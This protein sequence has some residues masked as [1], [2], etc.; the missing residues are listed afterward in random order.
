MERRGEK[1]V[2]SSIE[3]RQGFLGRPVLVVLVVS[4]ILVVAALALSYAGV[5]AH[6]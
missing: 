3:A 4:C 6:G 2:E 1:I 5:F